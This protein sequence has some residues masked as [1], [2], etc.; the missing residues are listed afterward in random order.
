MRIVDPHRR[1]ALPR[2]R[3]GEIWVAGPHVASGYWRGVDRDVF[4]GRLA[5]SG[6]GPFLRTGD[7][8]FMTPDGDLV[9]VDRLKD[10]VVVNGQNYVCH[11]L[12]L[13][14]ASSHALLS[15]DACVAVSV[16]AGDRPAVVVIAEFPRHALD[17]APETARAIRA[18]LL[19]THAL[20][21][22][23]VAFVGPRKL[24]RTTSGKLQRRL[25]A[26]RFMDGSLP[27]MAQ[28]G[29]QHGEGR[30]SL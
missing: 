20:P 4:E 14:A 9:F 28:Y 30:V 1:V 17:S 19:T 15:A 22:A 29:S 13:T 16:D 10:L 8:G 3:V 21:V 7:L 2:N 18:G 26:R 6:E 12:E 25:T 23:T 11:D 5:G 27:V 24:S